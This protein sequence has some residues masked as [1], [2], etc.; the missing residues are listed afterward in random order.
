MIIPPYIKPGDTIGIVSTARKVTKEE[1]LFSIKTL[2]NWGL[3]VVLG[4]NLFNKHHQFAGKEKE[5]IEDLQSMINNKHVKAILCARGG[6]GTVQ[7]IDKI[8]FSNLKKFP[9]WI[10]GYSDI[11]VL[12]SH[13]NKKGIAS[14]HATM[15]INFLKNTDESLI[16]LYN[17]LFGIKNRYNITNTNYNKTGQ[18]EAEL[19]GGNLSI[20]YSLL[21]SNS[22]LKIDNKIL[23]LEDI[24]E[25]LYHV[26]RMVINLKR[27]N[28]LTKL[29]G[30]I[31]GKMKD[32]NDNIIPYG[33]TA[34][35][36]ILK[37]TKEYSFPICFHF[38]A[39]HLSDNRSLK[40]GVKT[41]LEIN[42][43]HVILQQ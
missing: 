18:V 25:Y 26:D 35:E 33:E 9:K 24:D 12:H 28:K 10:I 29:K 2:Q 3:K 39:G 31:V 42:N 16:S 36:I 43:K 11:T 17:A 20:L 15:P 7:I 37:Y 22:D 13:L 8:D 1:L 40:F 5:R 27:N 41:Y 23:F 32:M 30:L 6:Y 38:P 4:K 19:V 21:G 14:I 34:E